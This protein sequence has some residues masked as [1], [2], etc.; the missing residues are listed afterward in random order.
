MPSHRAATERPDDEHVDVRGET[1]LGVHQSDY[2]S[3]EEAP[4]TSLHGCER[5]G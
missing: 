3:D 1:V 2:A 4:V 5:D